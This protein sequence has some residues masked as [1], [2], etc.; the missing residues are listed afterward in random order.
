V[1][2]RVVL[3]AALVAGAILRLVWPSDMEFKLDEQYNVDKVQR[4]PWTWTGQTSSTGIPNPG[5]G[6]WVLAV[7]G[8]GLGLSEPVSLAQGVMVLNVLAM[9][10]LAWFAVRVVRRESWLWATAL[11]AVSPIAVQ[12]SRKIW[13]QSV[14]APFVLVV[15]VAWWRRS[16]A[17]FAFAW[18][19]VGAWLG[20]I[21][22][23]GFFFAAGLAAWTW[24]FDRRG[25][26]WRWWLAG[27]GVGLAPAVPWLWDVATGDELGDS[28]RQ[29]PNLDFWR[30]WLVEYPLGFDL[31]TTFGSE[32]REFLEFPTAGG[33]PLRLVL[34]TFVVIAVVSLAVAVRAAPA[35]WRRRGEAVAALRRSPSLLLVTAGFVAFG[36]L[37]TF[38]FTH[39]HR[40]YLLVAFVLP[41]LTIALLALARPG[42]VTRWLLTVLAV[43]LCALSVQFLAYVHVN[44]GA[45]GGD[46]GVSYRA[47][48]GR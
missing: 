32:W 27:S 2:C 26:R 40:H 13:I 25:V 17:G 9:L 19:L 10:G 22:M 20:Q 33:T 23:A 44:E 48:P 15:L 37:L 43:A 3:V 4:D 12:F 18:G 42:A 31:H 45:A 8:R 16:A 5:M 38:S 1:L 41:F 34:V 24:L 29:V 39:V 6:I 35:L 11:L 28:P 21:Q 30:E 7:L 46:Y 36:L 14:L 47:Q